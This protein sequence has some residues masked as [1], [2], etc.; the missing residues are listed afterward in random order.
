MPQRSVKKVT[1]FQDRLQENSWCH[2]EVYILVS[3]RKN[4]NYY[5]IRLVGYFFNEKCAAWHKRG[6]QVFIFAE[7]LIVNSV[8]TKQVF[9]LWT[10]VTAS[11]AQYCRYVCVLA[12]YTGGSSKDLSRTDVILFLLSA[13]RIILNVGMSSLCRA[14]SWVYGYGNNNNNNNNNSTLFKFWCFADLAS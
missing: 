7:I 9:S 14:F 13:K 8:A 6:T 3:C 1:L 11:A 5:N 2:V 12:K 4:K 10:V